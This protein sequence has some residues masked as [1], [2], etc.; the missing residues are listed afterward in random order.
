MACGRLAVL[1]A[2]VTV[3]SVRTSKC[4][5][6]MNLL[7]DSELAQDRPDEKS[8]VL[9]QGRGSAVLLSWRKKWPHSGVDTPTQIYSVPRKPPTPSDSGATAG[10]I[11]EYTF[12]KSKFPM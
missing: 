7:R 9:G 8:L 6:T 10:T 4:R 1:E 2:I 11:P 5:A 3:A 12:E